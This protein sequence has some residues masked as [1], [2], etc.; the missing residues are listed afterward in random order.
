V[1]FRRADRLVAQVPWETAVEPAI[2]V[3][4]MRELRAAAHIGNQTRVFTM[5]VKDYECGDLDR[6]AGNP[7][8]LDCATTYYD[9]DVVVWRRGRVIG[10]VV[11]DKGRSFAV[12]LARKMLTRSEHPSD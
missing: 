9:T 2:T 6:T 12:E 3:Q 11:T 5:H 1:A 4:R 8:T 10:L 7:G